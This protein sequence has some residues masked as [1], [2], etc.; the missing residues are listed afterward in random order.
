MDSLQSTEIIEDSVN[1]SCVYLA[2]LSIPCLPVRPMHEYA[3]TVYYW[4]MVRCCATDDEWHFDD[5]DVTIRILLGDGA[6]LFGDS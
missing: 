4:G 3:Q 6:I 5:W 2:V 1:F